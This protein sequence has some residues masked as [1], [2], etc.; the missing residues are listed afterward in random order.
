MAAVLVET[1]WIGLAE[2][3]EAQVGMAVEVGVMKVVAD[4]GASSGRTC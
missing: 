3:G 2:S 1:G 4:G